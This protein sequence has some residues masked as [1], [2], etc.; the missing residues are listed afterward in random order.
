MIRGN[1]YA[2]LNSMTDDHRCPT[3]QQRHSF[4][5]NIRQYGNHRGNN[6]TPDALGL[7]A[8]NIQKGF[9][10][11]HELFLGFLP[12]RPYSSGKNNISVLIQQTDHYIGISDI[13]RKYHISVPP[14]PEFFFFRRRL[15]A[16]SSSSAASAFVIIGRSWTPASLINSR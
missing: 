13:H 14:F 9:K 8:V 10:F 6:H 5:Y 11:D 3:G 2:G 1:F 16:L 4:P 15:R 7:H 12:V